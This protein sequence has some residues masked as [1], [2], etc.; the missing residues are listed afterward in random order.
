MSGDGSPQ[1][2]EKRSSMAQIKA[3]RRDGE[4]PANQTKIIRAVRRIIK[5]IFLL[6]SLIPKKSA[7]EENMDRCIP[8]SA[9]T[10][11]KPAFLKSE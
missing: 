11:D 4:K 7:I 10:W 6:P 5:A 3:L 1:T 9:I 2:A 8:E